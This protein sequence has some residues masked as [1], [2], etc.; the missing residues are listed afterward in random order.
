MY[1][2]GKFEN[3]VVA[4]RDLCFISV[5]T[6]RATVEVRSLMQLATRRWLT[7]NSKLCAAF[8]TGE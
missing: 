4:L 1:E 7:A 6:D 8:P 3:D 2:V 5:D